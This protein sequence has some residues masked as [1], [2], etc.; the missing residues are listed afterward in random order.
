MK[1]VLFLILFFTSFPVI[2]QDLFDMYDNYF[3]ISN[4]IYDNSLKDLKRYGFKNN[5]NFIY[6]EKELLAHRDSIHILSQIKGVAI[7]FDKNTDLKKIID[8]LKLLPNLGYLKFDNIFFLK[9]GYT[10]Q[11]LPSNLLELSK[12]KTIAFYYSNEKNFKCD[13]LILSKLKNLKNLVFIGGRSDILQTH[14]FLKLKQLEGI[15]CSARYG[16]IIPYEI[17][18]FPN[19]KTFL[20]AADK[21]PNGDQMLK[22]LSKNQNIENLM[23]SYV[24]LNDS[25]SKSLSNFKNLKRLRLFG[26]IENPKLLFNSLSNKTINELYLSNNSLESDLSELTDFKQ[27]EKFYSSNNNL[28]KKLSINFFKLKNLSFIEIQGSK[29][30]VIDDNIYKLKKLET[31]KLHFNKLKKFTISNQN[32]TYLTLRNNFL[33]ELTD[34]IGGLS[35]LKYLDLSDNKLEFLPK[36][37]INLTLLDTLNLENNYLKSL[38]KDFG[39]LSNLKF[40]NLEQNILTSL[41]HSFPNLYRLNYLNVTAN[42]LNS[43][44]KNFGDLTSL[45]NLQ[46]SSNFI[47]YL[48]NSFKKLENLKRINLRYNNLSKLPTGFGNLK[49]LEFLYLGNKENFKY[50]FD[51]YNSDLHKFKK[52]SIKR[53]SRLMND[54]IFFPKDFVDLKKLK[55]IDLSNNYSLNNSNLFEILKKASF[56]DYT[57]N[58]DNCNISFLP[59]AGWKTIGVKSL[60]VSHNKIEKLPYNIVKASYLTT[61]DIRKNTG[62][63]LNM[64]ISSKEQ[65]SIYY[66]ELGLTNGE[67]LPN[68]MELAKAYA[69][70]SNKKYSKKQF[71]KAVEYA[72][73]AI[74]IDKKIAL[75]YLFESNLA[76]I[77]Y[78]SNM[79][80]KSIYYA[81]NF[82]QKDTIFNVRVLN[83][84]LPNFEYKYKSQLALGDTI[85]AITTLEIGSRDFS[86]NKWTEAGLLAKKMKMYTKAQHFFNKS[87]EFYIN[88][89]KKN[90]NNWG[91]HLSLL[92][93]YIIAE[94]FNKANEYLLNLKNKDIKELKYQFLLEYFNIILDEINNNESFFTDYEV[95]KEKLKKQDVN[96]TGWSFELFLQWNELNSLSIKKNLKTLT[97]LLQIEK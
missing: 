2:S 78:K 32:L 22:N 52:D 9:E 85:Q 95:L 56:K 70:Y 20:I 5:N 38:P 37:I 59:E 41:P 30:E 66:N 88:Y 24:P 14:N 65:L 77:Y 87:F 3:S 39:N 18:G 63:S 19:L 25:I 10:S 93:V 76:E 86:A 34:K 84:I 23:L 49:N 60:D 11:C 15:Y 79:F 92:E 71:E 89:L 47:E 53:K 82:L 45:E 74:S 83:S 1:K 96:F 4:K 7:K 16:P 26:K 8:H 46:G 90:N 68:T 75:N 48:P 73:K 21:Y 13:F 64:Y 80:E 36:S 69:K 54:I 51:R 17:N 44:P 55:V 72:E 35:S 27:L 33:A 67:I 62:D 50:Q 6:N 91:Y 57:L 97:R 61:L 58:I 28:G 29:L 31:L 42:D 12:L 43:F 81:N 94:E 40:L